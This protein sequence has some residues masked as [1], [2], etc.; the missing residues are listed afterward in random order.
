AF[1]ISVFTMDVIVDPDLFGRHD[2]LEIYKDPSVID[3]D[4]AR[5]DDLIT[6]RDI[7]QG[8]CVYC[9]RIAQHFNTAFYIPL[10]CLN[11]I[12][13]SHI[14]KDVLHFYNNRSARYTAVAP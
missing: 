2:L 1:Y 14:T 9:S 11:I 7:R 6:L 13:D 4:F 3:L 8:L 10:F 5:V 12:I